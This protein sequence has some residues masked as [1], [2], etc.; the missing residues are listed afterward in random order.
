MVTLTCDVKREKGLI[1]DFKVAS[2]L[3]KR[4]RV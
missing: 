3:F 2:N 1:E 4:L